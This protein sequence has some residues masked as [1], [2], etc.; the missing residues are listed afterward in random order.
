MFNYQRGNPRSQGVTIVN[1]VRREEAA[2]LLKSL[3]AE[4]VVVT[5]RW[6]WWWYMLVV[7]VDVGTYCHF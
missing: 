6:L 1:M 4:H 7:A 2:E 3:G 5:S